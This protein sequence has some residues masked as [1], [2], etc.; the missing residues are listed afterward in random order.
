MK[1]T[2]KLVISIILFFLIIVNLGFVAYAALP[3]IRTLQG[4]STRLGLR[5]L[6][7]SKAPVTEAEI[8]KTMTI[9]RSRIKK[10]STI[11]VLVERSQIPGE[12]I[13][14]HIP[15]GVDIQ[16]VKETIVE[17]GHLALKLVA[18]NSEIPFQTKE[19]ADQFLKTLNSAAF[20]ILPY[21]E[22]YKEERQR[23][24]YIIVERTAVITASDVQTARAIGA[25]NNTNYQIDFGLTPDGAAR[26]SKAT[27]EHLDE[28]LAIVLNNEVKSAPR[29]VGQI[30]DKGQI[31]GDFTRREAERMAIVLSSGELPHEIKIVSEK[32]VSSKDQTG[33][34]LFK[35]GVFAFTLMFLTGSFIYVVSR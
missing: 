18:K 23:T 9:I 33:K 35:T 7:E 25:Y 8:E 15:A 32:A 21:R 16:Q 30:S 17:P 26:L 10:L 29:I 31:T 2:K 1:Q 5:L 34:H 6:P 13:V 24:G 27:G 11:S 4:N 22:S 3:F 28:S 12:E 19:A 14:M 20:E